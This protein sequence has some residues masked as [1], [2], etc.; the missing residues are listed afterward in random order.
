MLLASRPCFG[1]VVDLAV[2][3]TVGLTAIGGA[4]LM[5]GEVAA[6]FLELLL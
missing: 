6:S 3:L 5:G 4:E 2:G 1:L